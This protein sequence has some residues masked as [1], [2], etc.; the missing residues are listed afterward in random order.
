MRAVLMALLLACSCG[1]GLAHASNTRRLKTT[2][3]IEGVAIC[4]VAL[5]IAGVRKLCEDG[6][7]LPRD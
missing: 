6:T 4:L 3:P 5:G 7:I 2:I 1:S